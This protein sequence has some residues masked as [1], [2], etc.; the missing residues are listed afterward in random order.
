[1]FTS[2]PLVKAADSDIT[3]SFFPPELQIT[4][5]QNGQITINTELRCNPETGELTGP[6]SFIPPEMWQ[7]YEKRCQRETTWWGKLLNKFSK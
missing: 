6:K 5:S 4:Q 2:I 1:M 3:P 7:E